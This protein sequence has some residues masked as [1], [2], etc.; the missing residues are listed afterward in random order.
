ME[1]YYN[2]ADSDAIS[3]FNAYLAEFYE[4]NKRPMPW[5]DDI[6]PFRVVVSEIMLQQTQV[7]RVMD[8]FPQFIQTFPDFNALAGASLEDVMR[9]WQGLGYNRRAKYLLEI[10]RAI[11][12][13]WNGIVPDD[14]EI[15]VT[16]P[17]IGTATAGSIV[18]FSY[19][20]PVVFIE[21]NIRRVFI[22]H[23]FQDQADV[24]DKEI[25]PVICCALNKNTPREWYYSLMD[26]GTFLAG[27]I[28]NPNRRSRHYAVQ[29]PFA[30]SDREIR[31][32]V[33]KVLLENGPTQYN[34]LVGI[35]G[36]QHSRT[37][38]I[39]SQMIIEGLIVKDHTTIHFS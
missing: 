36:D 23:F 5:R 14:P 20:R 15:L 6:T 4:K 7:P 25:I 31:G 39:I 10:S 35:V 37:E 17:G 2:P 13:K 19:N 16:L 30:G 12:E 22:H 29:S 11:V 28:K 9:A 3:Q 26:Y 38:K 32:Q 21:T 24:S 33:I 1:K 34:Q 27:K 18:A 8:Q